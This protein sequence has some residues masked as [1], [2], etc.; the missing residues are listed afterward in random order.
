MGGLASM[1]SYL[2]DRYGAN[3]TGYGR[4]FGAPSTN[5][6]NYTCAREAAIFLK[7]LNDRNEYG[8]LTYH[9]ENF[10]ITAPAGANLYAQIG[11]ENNSVRNNLNLF[12]IVKGATSDYCVVILT[13]NGSSANSFISD[14]LAVIH[15]KME[16]LH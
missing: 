16:G 15:T 10:G 12:G 4:Y 3:V 14:L 1:T 6:D 13:Q 2:S 5:G 8:R 7:T 9:P 11:T